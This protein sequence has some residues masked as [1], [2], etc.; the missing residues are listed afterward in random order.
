MN[1]SFFYEVKK[2]GRYHSE[3][4]PYIKRVEYAFYNERAIR[5]AVYEARLESF[6]PEVR[7]GSGLPDPTATSA[8]KNLSPVTSVTIEGAELKRPESWLGV[9]EKTYSWCEL[10]GELFHKLAKLKYA[11][12]LKTVRI[13]AELEIVQEKFF[14]ILEKVRNYAALQA[15]QRNLIYVE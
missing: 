1:Q 7:T 2:L 6:T 11:S 13:C 14:R 3:T 12:G 15:A 4:R 10:Q 9:V 8:I 5:E